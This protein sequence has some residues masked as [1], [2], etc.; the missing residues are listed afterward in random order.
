[1]KHLLL[2][3][4]I[5]T[6]ILMAQD[7]PQIVIAHRGASGYLPEHTLEAK[8][9]AHAQ[10]AHYIEQDL[11]LTKDDVPVVLHDIH[12][13]TVTD[14]VEKFPTRKRDDGRYYALDFTLAELKTLR[15]TERFNAV[16]GKQVYPNRFPKGQG[17]FEIATLAEELQLIQ[18]LNH[19]TGRVAGIYPE[20]KQPAWHLAQGHDLSRIV[21][22]ILHRYG[23]KTKDDPCY[24]QCF[25]HDEV[26]RLRDELGWKGRLIMLMSGGKTGPGNTDFAHL[27][28][29][30]GLVELAKVA[31]GIGPE[32]KTVISADREPTS[33]VKDAHT[34]GLKVHA[35]T[36]RVDELPKFA[37]SA[38]DLLTLLFQKAGVD[39]L[40]SDFPDVALRGLR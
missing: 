4:L 3:S 27:R 5:P 16:T 32:V 25:E 38:E 36:L 19:S 12:I 22:P 28:T 26:K 17:R 13:D 37:Q 14:V 9:M 15:A 34:C 31:N 20:I 1:M 23:Y 11:V 6:A 35:Y 39:G 24:I 33:L 29:P 18:G 8:A 10:G 30:A 2:L 21:L 7:A 40:F